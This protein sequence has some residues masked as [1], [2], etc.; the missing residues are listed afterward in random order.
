MKANRMHFLRSL[1]VNLS[2]KLCVYLCLTDIKNISIDS[3]MSTFKLTNSNE[4]IM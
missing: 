1:P 4:M 3:E 2:A